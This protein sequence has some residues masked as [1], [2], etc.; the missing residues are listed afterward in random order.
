MQSLSMRSAKNFMSSARSS[1][2]A[3]KIAFRKRSARSASAAR[4]AKAISG[5]IIQNSARWRLVLLFSARK[6]GPEGVDLG[7][8]QAVG[9]DVEL[10][11]DRQERLAPEEVARKIDLALGG[12]GTA[13]RL[14]RSSVL[15]RNISPA[16]RHRWR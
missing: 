4:S 16:P 8:R 9:L 3:L 14:A 1:S 15:T 12:A 7:Q 6:V 2:S 13:P 5:S 11:A 10:A